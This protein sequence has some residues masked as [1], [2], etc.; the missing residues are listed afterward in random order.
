MSKHRLDLALT[1]KEKEELQE[2]QRGGP[3]SLIGS[4]WRH[5]EASIRARPMRFEC[6]FSSVG[7]IS[8]SGCASSYNLL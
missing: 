8:E 5:E 6:F 2:D 3:C 7:G 1:E 4:K